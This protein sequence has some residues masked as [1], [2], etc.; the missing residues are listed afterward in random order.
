MTK[1]WAHR[2]ASAYAPENTM[3]AFQLANEMK[4]D[5]IELDVQLTKDGEIV[6]IHDEIIDR[7]SDGK[8]KVRDYTLKELKALH[9]H[10]THPEY[11]DA[12]IPTLKEVLDYVKTTS[13][14]VNIELKTGI[15]FYEGLT[16][17][18]ISLVKAL[19][20]EERV[21][22]SSFNHYTIRE[23][24]KIAPQAKTGLLYADG[25]IDMP[26]YGASLGADALHPAL[27]N[28]QYP[29]FIGLCR[30][31]NLKIHV[32]TV[33]RK[34]DMKKLCELGIDAII[35]N[36]PDRAIKVREAL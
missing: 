36:Y 14:T 29:D 20:M 12:R 30:K 26:M 19:G 35:T 33:N 28:L 16:E 34:E 23:I 1:I 27:Y 31:K 24:K 21:I 32:W 25:Y 3:E 8:G 4:A 9:F 5:G 10:K 22:Y 18:T 2:G 11:R 7:V 6:V 15:I 13:M 17:K